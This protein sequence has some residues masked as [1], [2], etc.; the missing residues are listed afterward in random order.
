MTGVD[1]KKD[2]NSLWQFK[3]IDVLMDDSLEEAEPCRIGQRLKCGD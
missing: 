2:Y 3:E 1:D